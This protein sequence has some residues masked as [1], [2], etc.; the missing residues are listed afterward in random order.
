MNKILIIDRCDECHYSL[1]SASDEGICFNVNKR[2]QPR[3][4][5]DPKDIPDECPL[6]DYKEDV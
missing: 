3:G 6:S 5:D 4:L 1:F 2:S